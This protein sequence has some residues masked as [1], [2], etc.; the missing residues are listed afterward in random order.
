MPFSIVTAP[1]YILDNNGRVPL[2]IY[3]AN[4]YQY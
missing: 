1:F 4:T 2:S 3:L